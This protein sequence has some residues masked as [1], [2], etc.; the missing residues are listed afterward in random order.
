MSMH[1]RGHIHQ[2]L[3][4]LRC[5]QEQGRHSVIER[6]SYLAARSLVAAL[7]DDRALRP[8]GTAGGAL[9]RSLAARSCRNEHL[10]L[11]HMYTAHGILTHDLLTLSAITAQ[12]FA[13]FR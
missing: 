13:S 8:G 1:S 4:R 9:R 5:D 2:R 11:T 7:T 6:A 3:T 12:P 10:L